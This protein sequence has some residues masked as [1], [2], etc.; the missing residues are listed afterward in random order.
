MVFRQCD[1][2][3]SNILKIGF[4]IDGVLADFVSGFA[5]LLPEYEIDSFSWGLGLTKEQERV[6]WKRVD[7]SPSF[8]YDLAILN[9]LPAIDPQHEVFFITK[10]RHTPG[11]EPTSISA[12]RW[13]HDKL[14]VS[15]PTVLALSNKGEVCR[16][17]GIDTFIDDKPENCWDVQD[18]SPNTE[19]F[20]FDQPWNRHDTR[21]LRVKTLDEYLEKVIG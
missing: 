9:S 14:G 15:L 4:D 6:G 16:A 3:Y 20:L 18:E 11:Q 2:S 10:R 5:A 1:R 13:L 19:T 8:W 21:V 17:I 12:A 7:A